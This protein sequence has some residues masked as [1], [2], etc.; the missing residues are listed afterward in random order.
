MDRA[1]FFARSFLHSQ[2]C[3]YRYRQGF[4]RRP[5]P[6]VVSGARIEAAGASPVD[7]L[8]A[9]AARSGQ[10][11]AKRRTG[12]DAARNRR[13][14][15]AAIY[16]TSNSISCTRTMLGRRTISFRASLGLPRPARGQPAGR[17]H[18]PASA[19]PSLE[20][21]PHVPWSDRE[22]AI[23]ATG[24]DRGRGAGLAHRSDLCRASKCPRN[25][26]ARTCVPR[27]VRAGVSRA[28][29]S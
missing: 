21:Q 25:Y 19:D 6:I 4:S 22:F 11:A 28:T 29:I 26:P 14:S 16:V 12:S 17:V 1:L 5:G 23:R 20:I 10:R 24:S 3:S 18:A 9:R 27:R 7:R 2:D 15:Y 13:H 8:P